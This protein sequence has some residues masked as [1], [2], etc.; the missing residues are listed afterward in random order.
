MLSANKPIMQ[1]AFSNMLTKETGAFYKASYDAFI[2]T[3]EG[4]NSDELTTDDEDLS[5]EIAKQKQQFE[6]KQKDM[7]KKFASAF[8]DALKN[9]NFDKELADQI[10]NHVKSLQFVITMMPQGLA[11]IVSPVGPCTGSMIISDATANIQLV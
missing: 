7:A 2:T 4:C 5:K 1:Q 6:I 9:A 10:D 3:M 8:V 11:T